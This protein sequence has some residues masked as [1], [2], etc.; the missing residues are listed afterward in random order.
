M[1]QGTILLWHPQEL[2]L[3][4]GCPDYVATLVA[5]NT[6]VRGVWSPFE[7]RSAPLYN[8]LAS[9]ATAQVSNFSNHSGSS[10]SIT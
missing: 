8:P 3:A 4:Y 2:A 9:T 6:R 7:M 1:K 5:T 10:A